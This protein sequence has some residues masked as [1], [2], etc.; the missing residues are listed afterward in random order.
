MQY[1]LVHF[2]SAGDYYQESENGM[3]TRYCDIT[4]ATVFVLPPEGAA[5]VIDPNPPPLAW[6]T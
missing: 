3:V 4:G 2:E 6:M 5:A 1:I